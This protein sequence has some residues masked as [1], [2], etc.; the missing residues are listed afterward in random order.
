MNNL[1]ILKRATGS[2]EPLRQGH[3]GGGKLNVHGDWM[4]GRLAENGELTLDELC[5][6]LAERGAIVHRS[7]VGRFLHRLGLNHKKSLRTSEHQRP[8]MAQARDLW[9]RRRRRFFNKALARL[10]FIDE[11]STNTPSARDGRREVGVTAAMPSS[12]QG[13]P[14]PSSPG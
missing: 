14:K 6:E 2:L 10:I 9:M 7:N 8:E 11:T 1:V 4:R 12:V 3:F 5:V 13:N